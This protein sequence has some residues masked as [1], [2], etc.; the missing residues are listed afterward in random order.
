MSSTS[1]P[2]SFS[3]SSLLSGLSCPWFGDGIG[4][5]GVGDDGVGDEGIGDEG[6]G[7]E[8]VGDEGVGDDGGS[9]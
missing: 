6:V 2:C 9:C 4:D 5:N 7:D 1:T 3:S 8:G